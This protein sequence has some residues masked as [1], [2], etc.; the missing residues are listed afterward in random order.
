MPYK[1]SG[2][3]FSRKRFDA[4]LKKKREEEE[5]A[6]R[7]LEKE[8]R[9]EYEDAYASLKGRLDEQVAR[10]LEQANAAAAQQVP[11]QGPSRIVSGP[12]YSGIAQAHHN[13]MMANDEDEAIALLLLS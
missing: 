2:P 11:I 6:L 10:L 8:R 3:H 4:I 9:K 12:D 1:A 13:L 5:A 7:A